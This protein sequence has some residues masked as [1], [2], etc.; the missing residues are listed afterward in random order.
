MG[1]DLHH[2]RYFRLPSERQLTNYLCLS[3]EGAITLVV[4]VLSFWMIEDFPD[5][6]V[7]F[8]FSL[9]AWLARLA[10][11]NHPPSA[12]FLSE[13]ERTQATSESKP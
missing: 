6:F 8:T 12:R 1:L 7:P 4:A 2:V 5:T 9:R 13:A 10:K 3:R 11:P